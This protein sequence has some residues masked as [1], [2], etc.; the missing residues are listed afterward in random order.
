MA[1]CTSPA[2]FANLEEHLQAAIKQWQPIKQPL[3]QGTMHTLPELQDLHVIQDY[4]YSMVAGTRL[5]SL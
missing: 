4:F 1:A 2:D 3:P 5:Y